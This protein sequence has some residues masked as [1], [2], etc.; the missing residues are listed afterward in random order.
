MAASRLAKPRF[1]RA[2]TLRS[3]RLTLRAHRPEDLGETATLWGDAAVVRHIGGQPSRTDEENWGR[4][5]RYCGLWALAGMGYW[6]VEE[7]ATGRYVGEAGL[8]DFKR[9][10]TPSFAGAPEAGWVIAPW[11]QGR[12]YATETVRAMLAWADETFAPPRVCA[13]IEPEN[14][15]SVRVAEKCG[16]VEFARTAYKDVTAALFERAA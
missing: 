11:A 3:E 6:A 13:L 5:L 16:F 2:P 4:L 10:I 7:T 12:G 1:D 15:A 8:A 9:E 14:A